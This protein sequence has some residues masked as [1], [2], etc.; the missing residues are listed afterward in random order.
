[1][2]GI[3]SSDDNDK[4]SGEFKEFSQSK[5]R[6]MLHFESDPIVSSMNIGELSDNIL[7]SQVSI[8]F[9]I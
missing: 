1:M 6:R 5:R 4:R 7:Q 8:N 9:L 2:I 3:F